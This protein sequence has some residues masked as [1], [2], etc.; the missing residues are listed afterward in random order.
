MN[1]RK[2]IFNILSLLTISLVL[3]S[4]D[5]LS[6]KRDN[7]YIKYQVESSTI[8]YGGKLDVEISN[9]NGS[10][11]LVINQREDWETTIGPVNKGF[12]ASLKATKMGWNGQTIENHLKLK[13]R[14]LVSKNN[15]PFALKKSDEPNSTRATAELQHIVE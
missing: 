7:Y 2:F 14:I 9:E 11:P 10:L 3:T 4:C 1:Y 5:K 8:Y 6:L 13:L 12:K 15:G